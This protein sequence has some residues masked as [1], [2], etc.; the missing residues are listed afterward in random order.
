[1][2]NI[3]QHLSS[4]KYRNYKIFL[5]GFWWYIKYHKKCYFIVALHNPPPKDNFNLKSS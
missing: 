5:P 1:M 2:N 3:C 4:Q